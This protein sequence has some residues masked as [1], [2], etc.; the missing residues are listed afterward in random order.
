MKALILVDIQNDFLPS[1]ALAVPDGNDIFPYVN[2]LQKDFEMVIASQDWHPADHGSFASNHTGKSVGDFV[3]LSGTQQY[4][5]PDHCIQNT[6]GAQFSNQLDQRA[7][8]RI[9]KKGTDSK[10]DSYSAFFDN[11]RQADTGLSQYL[12]DNGVKSIHIV[13][14]A[15]DYCVKFTCL[16]GIS[17]GFEVLLHEKGTRSVNVNK[18]DHEKAIDEMQS[19][20]VII[21]P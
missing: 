8:K 2:D 4:L 15:C 16:D 18:G 17:E 11:N 7:I 20:G 14:L 1:G 13:G 10:I 21:I 12:K 19:K 3:Q 5:W 6:D 9:F